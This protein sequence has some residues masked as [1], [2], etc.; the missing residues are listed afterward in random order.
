MDKHNNNTNEKRRR[1]TSEYSERQIRRRVQQEF[2]HS[3]LEVE[4]ILHSCISTESN[5]IINESQVN[6]ETNML[7]KEEVCEIATNEIYLKK[8][9]S[10]RRK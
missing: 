1:L 8:N 5:R 3:L 6:V 2:E 4:S 7:N 9:V 10:R